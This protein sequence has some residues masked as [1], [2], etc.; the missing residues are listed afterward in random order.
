[1][2]ATDNRPRAFFDPAA[3]TTTGTGFR[4]L[5]KV[6]T[7]RVYGEPAQWTDVEVVLTV[8]QIQSIAIRA[9]KNKS[10]RADAGAVFAK[11]AYGTGGR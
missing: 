1:M 9:A 3:T 4:A 7:E 10:K 11:V 5:V 8:Q 2:T 6:R